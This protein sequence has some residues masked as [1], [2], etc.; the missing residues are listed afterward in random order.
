MRTGTKIWL[1]AAILLILS[2]CMVFG[3]VMSMLGWNFEKLYT[4][5]YETNHH[6]ITEAYTGI[7]LATDTADV[8]LVLSEDGKT[9]VEICEQEKIFHTVEVKDGI[10][11]IRVT[12]TRKWYEHIGIGFGNT[13]ITLTL[14]AGEYGDLSVR[15]NTGD[16]VIPEGLAFRS[17]TLEATTGDVECNATAE[18]MK[19]K[20]STGGISVNGASVGVLELSVSTGRVNVTDAAVREELSVNVSTGKAV[21]RGVACRD[22][23]SVG[24]TGDLSMTDLIATGKLSVERS[25]GD[26]TLTRCDAAEITVT[27]STGDVEGSLLSGK[28][29]SVH[30]NTGHT[31]Y[32]GSVP[33]G[34]ACVIRTSTG[35]IRITVE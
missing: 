32:P 30:S 27:T 33:G 16:V 1:V 34:G 4:V 18:A 11:E 6:E 20:T 12:D 19:I 21:L 7:S 31:S 24:D 17:V 35:T 2:G 23:T 15:V 14:P 5:K 26:V 9:G 29:F 8:T 22:F 28:D 25:T 10:L 13:K 3:G